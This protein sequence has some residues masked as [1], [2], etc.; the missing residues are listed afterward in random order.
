M[1]ASTAFESGLSFDQI[2]S[3]VKRRSLAIVGLT[4]AGIVAG[5]GAALV[6]PDEWQAT[7]VLQVGQITR[8]LVTN[9]DTNVIVQPLEPAARTVERMSLR[10]FQDRVLESLGLPLDRTRSHATGLIRDYAQPALQH[11]GDLVSISARGYSR[12]QAKQIV[13]A[14]EKLVI[15]SHRELLQPSVDRMKAELEQSKAALVAARKR[16][17]ALNAQSTTMLKGEE[18]RFSADVLRDNLLQ[19][20]EEELHRFA[21]RIEE[22]QEDLNPARTFNTRPLM[23]GIEVNDKPVFPKKSTAAQLGALAGLVLGICLGLLRDSRDRKR[24]R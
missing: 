11:D 20:N 10:Q 6:I 16:E 14:Y 19:R 15:D 12:E 4:V 8:T 1:Q 13:A 5:I 24:A 9:G 2:A 22:L 21:L 18:G 3:F 23:P 7:D 17:A